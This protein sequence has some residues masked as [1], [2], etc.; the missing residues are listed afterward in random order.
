MRLYELICE[1]PLPDEWDQ[2]IYSDRVP[3]KKRIEYAKQM[4]KRIGSGSSRVAFEIPYQGRKTILK[5]AKNG[6]GMAQNEQESQMLNDYYLNQLGLFI[7]MIDYDEQSSTPTWIHTEFADKASNSDFIAA[8]GG[9][10]EDLVTYAKQYFGKKRRGFGNP[11][12]IDGES[13]LAVDFIDFT[14]NFDA[15]IDDYSALQNWGKY[16]GKLVIIDAGLSDDIYKQHYS[17]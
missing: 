12:V 2:S 17:S 10:P 14:G 15:N 8:C 5:V 4:A 1:A 16:K 9:K 11:E 13:E 3:F 7:P 6:K